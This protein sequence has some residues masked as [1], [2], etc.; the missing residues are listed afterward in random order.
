MNI[1]TFGLSRLNFSHMKSNGA[2]SGQHAWHF[3]VKLR[4]N[5]P[6]TE[7]QIFSWK[8]SPQNSSPSVLFSLIVFF[9][10]ALLFVF[11]VKI[12][13]SY[14]HGRL[15]SLTRCSRRWRAVTT[16]ELA[17]PF[18]SPADRPPLCCVRVKSLRDVRRNCC[19]FHLAP[20]MSEHHR[21]NKSSSCVSDS[22]I[23]SG[24]TFLIF[25]LISVETKNLR[26]D[27]TCASFEST[28][29]IKQAQSMV[30]TEK[31]TACKWRDEY[32]Y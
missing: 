10:G 30:D 9:S 24:M 32:F 5:S 19:W 13:F 21:P 25:F 11:C 22:L 3:N 20:W 2:K 8:I 29:C 23:R 4:F 1:E 12:N 16:G 28:H 18:T 6:W 31:Q 7:P 17:G 15:A 27:H 26:L 14:I